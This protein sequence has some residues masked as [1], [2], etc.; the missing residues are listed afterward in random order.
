M[1][2]S[3]N[4][5]IGDPVSFTFEHR[6]L[7]FILILAM[8]MSFLGAVLDLMMCNCIEVVDKNIIK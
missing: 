2:D 8:F 1:K 3:G 6:M 7:N 5:L 4:K